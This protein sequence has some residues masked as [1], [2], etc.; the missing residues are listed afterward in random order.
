MARACSVCGQDMLMMWPSS[1]Q[2]ISRMWSACGNGV[3]MM[4]LEC[5]QA[6]A[7]IRLGCGPGY[8]L[9]VAM[10][11]SEYYQEVTMF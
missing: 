6:V 10:I 1:G 2:D 4:W 3:A 8:S 11:S 7:M 5:C 9:D